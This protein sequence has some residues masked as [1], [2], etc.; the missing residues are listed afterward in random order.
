[1][2]HCE[3]FLAISSVLNALLYEYMKQ[4]NRLI[5]VIFFT[6]ISFRRKKYLVACIFFNR[7]TWFDNDHICPRFS[8][9][10]QNRTCIVEKF[11]CFKINDDK[12]HYFPYKNWLAFKIKILSTKIANK[13]FIIFV[14]SHRILRE[15]FINNC[16]EW[17]LRRKH[18]F[19]EKL[20]LPL[21]LY[22]MR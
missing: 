9:D 10:L 4:A 22:A 12:T 5:F 21:R 19:N 20:F 1:M 6:S 17:N 13:T 16:Q 8:L 18:C 14:R 7:S 11:L 2:R 3:S 15:I